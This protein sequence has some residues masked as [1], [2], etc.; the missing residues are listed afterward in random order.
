MENLIKAITLLRSSHES[1]IMLNSAIHQTDSKLKAIQQRLPSIEAGIT[2][3]ARSFSLLP[4]KQQLEFAIGPA[5]S[6]VRVY[7]MVCDL[8]RTLDDRNPH[9]NL[10]DFV[11]LIK[12]LE[13]A[14]RFLTSNSKLVLHG[15]EDILHFLENRKTDDDD[16]DDDGSYRYIGD[17][18]KS[19]RIL[20][21]LQEIEKLS[22][23]DGGVLF[24]SLNRLE[25]EF[26]ILLRMNEFPIQEFVI[27]KLHFMIERMSAN[28]LLEDCKS[29]YVKVRSSKM[30]SAMDALNLDY[31]ET[32][33][34]E[35]DSVHTVE[36][37]VD[38]WNKDLE[39]AINHIFEVEYRVCINVFQKEG[40]DEFFM[41]CIAVIFLSSGRI[42]SFLKFAYG[43]TKG[44]KDAIKLLKLLEVFAT[45]YNL[46][47]NFN[48]LFVGKRCIEIRNQTRDLVKN[49]VDAAC[50][51]FWELSI[52]VELQ[53][54][55]P[56]PPD[57]SIPKL[58]T[59]V[60]DYCNELLEDSYRVTMI[61]ILEINY[62]WNR[63]TNFDGRIFYDE[64]RKVVSVLEENMEVW[65]G[66][67]EE[68]SMSDLFAMKVHDHLLE[69]CRG[70]KLGDLMG[71]A[72]LRRHEEAASRHS[73]RFLSESWG[74]LAS[75]LIEPSGDE[76]KQL[77]LRAKIV[78]LQE[79]VG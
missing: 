60:T 74:K 76:K 57:G 53:R 46:R 25:E 48:L 22:R 75:N 2:T 37:K 35:F 31:L 65:A 50:K 77:S 54:K 34:S 70:T 36:D 63:Q 24:R 4:I 16:D 56:P 43:L 40:D 12:Q 44:K 20:I 61:Q 29:I 39:F 68:R 8:E 73:A 33:L 66:C 26:E 59:F 14:L 21:H 5:S 7:E 32:L 28:D 19:L 18:K 64:I 52:Q 79:A 3:V 51:I 62:G 15:L 42:Q 23:L 27:E 38:R 30:K 49:V 9:Q 55:S 72:W 58:L 45:L 11:S 41:D 17:V 10:F 6:V 69:N 67:Y 47:S 71:E 78:V 13:D 1:S